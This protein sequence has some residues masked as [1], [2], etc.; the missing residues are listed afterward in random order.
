MATLVCYRLA[1]VIAWK[2][3]EQIISPCYCL[4][5]LRFLII[6]YIIFLPKLQLVIAEEVVLSRTI[7]RGPY[8]MMTLRCKQA[9]QPPIID[10][11]CPHLQ[12]FSLRTFTQTVPRRHSNIINKISVITSMFIYILNDS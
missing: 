2:R 12:M 8:F 7:M 11:L 5:V 10:R 4:F 3:R 6:F 9:K 1:R